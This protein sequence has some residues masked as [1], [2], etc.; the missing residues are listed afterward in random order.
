MKAILHISRIQTQWKMFFFSCFLDWYT[1][2]PVIKPA[3]KSHDLSQ[4]REL[5]GFPRSEWV[6]GRPTFILAIE[7][8]VY[9]DTP[10]DYAEIVAVGAY[11]RC[12]AKNLLV[13]EKYNR[14]CC[15]F[16]FFIFFIKET[17]RY[18]F[19]CSL[20]KTNEKLKFC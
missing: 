1:D 18:N 7:N 14:H 11:R 9:V 6:M 5:R 15:C 8:R 12:S 17:Y 19:T 2:I 16:D 10:M 20:L 4:S 13:F 3:F